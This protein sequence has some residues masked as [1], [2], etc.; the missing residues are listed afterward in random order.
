MIKETKNFVE[1]PPIIAV[2]GHIDHGKSTLLD[3]IRKTNIVDKEAGGITQ[4]LSAY[5]VVHKG[6]GGKEHK[7]TFLDTPGHEA[8]KAIRARGA[9]VADIGVL[10]VSAEDGVKPQTLEALLVIKES[11]IPYVVAINKI[12]KEGANI[13]R[14]KQNLAENDVFV[15]GYGGE[16]PW[17]AISAKVGTGVSELL[18]LLLLVAELEELKANP[19]LQ[20]KGIIIESNLDSK[21]G[22][23]ATAIITDGT[24]KKGEFAQCGKSISP[25]RIVDDF[26]GKPIETASF[27]TPIRIVGW[28]SAPTVGLE[29][30]CFKDKK[31]ALESVSKYNPD[32]EKAIKKEVD[33]TKTVIPIILKADTSGSLDA[34][35]YEVGKLANDRILPTVVLSGIG[36]VTEND[37]RAASTNDN[38]F[39]IGFHTKV[40]PQAES[41][42]L[43]LGTPLHSFDIIYKMTEWLV[44]ALKERTPAIESEEMKGRAKIIKLFS[45]TR[46][47]QIIGG[48]VE[49]GTISVNEVVKILRRDADIGQG[50]IKE[51]QMQK[52]KVSSV[53]EGKEFGAMVEAKIEIA[54]S[55]RIESFTIVKR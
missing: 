30:N 41:L 46:D 32:E 37:V 31:G 1:R 55:D 9:H 43:R 8:F 24:L 3:Y 49:T 29:F 40:E 17:V 4:H 25:L 35:I 2:M 26:L 14:T 5:E 13:D 53:E 11:K 51:L 16:I 54:P 22:I 21:K 48:K 36:P 20:A 19:D 45:K 50:R 18:D 42:A 7:I 34:L 15:E 12:D 27:S 38:A 23:T 28:D 44:D 39:I 6:K 33:L 47:K 10:V 52:N